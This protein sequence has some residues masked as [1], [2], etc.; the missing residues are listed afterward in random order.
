[1]RNIET[2]DICENGECGHAASLIWTGNGGSL[3]ITRSYMQ[4]KWCDCC[5]TKA[6]LEHAEKA[7][8]R[9]EELRTRLAAGCI[10]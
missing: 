9:L 6:Q 8:A 1:M 7:V 3:A 10:A 4:S 2:G 5:A